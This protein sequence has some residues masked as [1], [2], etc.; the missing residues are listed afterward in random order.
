MEVEDGMADMKMEGRWREGRWD[1]G[2][3]GKVE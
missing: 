3:E 2:I 1:S